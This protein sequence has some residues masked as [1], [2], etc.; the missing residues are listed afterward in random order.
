MVNES[1]IAGINKKLN[2]QYKAEMYKRLTRNLLMFN[3]EM[4]AVQ[5]KHHKVCEELERVDD[6]V[7][8]LSQ[9]IQSQEQLYSYLRKYMLD[10]NIRMVYKCLGIQPMPKDI[11]LSM[12]EGGA[13]FFD[14]F[15][16]AKP[17]KFEVKTIDAN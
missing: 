14:V 7:L 13:L 4:K 16:K 6:I 2:D 9:K 3:V 10:K 5:E 8:K 15:T 11:K 1:E 17:N 12:I